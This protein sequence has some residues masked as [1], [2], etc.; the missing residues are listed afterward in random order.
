MQQVTGHCGKCGAPYYSESP[1]WGVTPPPVNP[2]CM[3]W[4]LPVIRWTPSTSPILPKED[5]TGHPPPG[6][7]D[8]GTGDP[9]AGWYPTTTWSGG[10]FRTSCM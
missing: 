4:N 10:S 6:W 8:S 3:C 1:W 5:S 7:P 9:P 2:T